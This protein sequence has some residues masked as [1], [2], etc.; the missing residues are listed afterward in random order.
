MLGRGTPNAKQQPAPASC[1][2]NRFFGLSGY[3]GSLASAA[4][5]S[6]LESLRSSLDAFAWLQSVSKSPPAVPLIFRESIGEEVALCDRGRGRQARATRLAGGST[7]LLGVP[8]RRG[9]G[10]AGVTR[11]ADPGSFAF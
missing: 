3:P 6:V 10:V 9:T 11:R 4:G 5:G 8:A 2:T 1:L 7:L